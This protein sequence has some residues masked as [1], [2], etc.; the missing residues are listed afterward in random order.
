MRAAA[1]GIAAATAIL[2]QPASA[3]ADPVVDW[4]AAGGGLFAGPVDAT[5]D[6][7]LDAAGLAGTPGPTGSTGSEVE[8]RVGRPDQPFEAVIAG[9]AARHGLDPK[10][11]HALVAVE[12]AYRADA[13]SPVGALGLAQLMPATAK[14]LGVADRRDPAANVAGGA[15]YLAR[16]I[17]RFGDVRLALAA[18]NAGPER[19]ARLG[20]VPEIAETKAYVA[21]VVD[22]YLA[23]TAGRSI[24]SSRSCSP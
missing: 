24:R 19:V 8:A 15:A 22:C 3:W 10:L 18:Y 5:E 17:V 12:S 9:A 21:K 4:R 16:Q 13:R 7:V 1:V 11:L 14:E 2:A 6:A 20:R 23:L